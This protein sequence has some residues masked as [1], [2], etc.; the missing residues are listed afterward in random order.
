MR[1]KIS[2]YFQLY[3]FVSKL[4]QTPFMSV[5]F[6]RNIFLQHPKK[7]KKRFSSLNLCERK[8]IKILWTKLNISVR[9]PLVPVSTICKDTKNPWNSLNEFYCIN[10]N[11]NRNNSVGLFDCKFFVEFHNSRK[12]HDP[13]G[14]KMNILNCAISM[15]YPHTLFNVPKRRIRNDFSIPFVFLQRNEEIHFN[16]QW[17]FAMKN[18]SN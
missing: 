17:M 14:K 9:L 12:K 7:K 13:I 6:Y 16:W 3:I 11:E 2:L 1:E 4:S 8:K 5:F 10:Q 15:K 18:N